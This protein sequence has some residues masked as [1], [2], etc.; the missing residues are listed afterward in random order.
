MRDS[1]AEA[2][3]APADVLREPDGRQP[4]KQT[5]RPPWRHRRESVYVPRPVNFPV[6]PVSARRMT[7]QSPQR[8]VDDEFGN[9][10]RIL[11]KQHPDQKLVVSGDPE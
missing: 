5:P 7:R 3:R 10:E 4:A 11:V 2:I 9:E 6:L 1:A 8:H